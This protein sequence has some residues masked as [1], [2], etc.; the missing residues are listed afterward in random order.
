V[1]SPAETDGA[2]VGVGGL[3]LGGAAFVDEFEAAEAWERF[4]GGGGGGG[5]V[6]VG[7]TVGFGGGFIVVEVVGHVSNVGAVAGVVFDIGVGVG[8]VVSVVGDGGG[9]GRRCDCQHQG[10]HA[11]LHVEL[12]NE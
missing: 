6:T 5:G 11:Q 1:V 3:A 10:K 9:Q 4:V 2:D 8:S 12:G 7:V